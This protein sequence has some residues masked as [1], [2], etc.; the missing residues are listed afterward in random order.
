MLCKAIGAVP[1]PRTDDWLVPAFY[2]SGNHPENGQGTFMCSS[3][4]MGLCLGEA[5]Y[6]TSSRSRPPR[7][8]RSRA[9]IAPA[10]YYSD[11][12][13]DACKACDDGFVPAALDDGATGGAHTRCDPC[14]AGQS[15]R[16]STWTRRTRSSRARARSCAGSSATPRRCR[17]TRSTT[18]RSCVRARRWTRACGPTTSASR[19]ARRLDVL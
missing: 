19:R 8:S 16:R 11:A 5:T 7:P 12:G 6:T 1:V 17:P 2:E 13:K 10:D 9:T 18:R 15:R 4:Q 3:K 14:A